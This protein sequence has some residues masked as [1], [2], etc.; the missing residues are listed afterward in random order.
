MNQFFLLKPKGFKSEEN[1]QLIREMSC[2][3]CN[4]SPPS[5]PEHIKTVGSGGGDNLENL[6]PLCREHHTEAHTIGKKT[7]YKKYSLAIDVHRKLNYLPE[8]KR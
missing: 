2:C 7:F 8:L 3:V 1:L 4:H 6:M 5:D